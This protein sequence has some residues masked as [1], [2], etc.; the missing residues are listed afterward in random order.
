MALALILSGC[1]PEERIWWSPDG[2]QALVLV[3]G[4]LH[5]VKPG[6]ELGAP[7]MGGAKI[8]TTTSMAGLSWLRDGSG[9]VLCR[10]LKI[11]TWK[12]AARLVPA[13]EAKKIELLA[14]AV[15][16]WLAGAQ[17][18]ASKPSEAE[19]LLTSTVAGN[20]DDFLLALLCAYRSQKEAVAKSILKLPGGA[21]LLKKLNGENSQFTVNEICVV[22]FTGDGNSAAPHPLA[23]SLHAMAL[24]QV[25]PAQSVV[26]WLQMNGTNQIPSLEVSSLDGSEHA[27]VCESAKATFDWLPDGRSIIFATPVNGQSDSLAKI[28][29]VAV[30]AES[31]GLVKA[32]SEELGLALLLDPPRLQA[33]PDGR[34]LFSS[35][36]ATLPAAGP[37]FA[38]QLFILSADGKTVTGVATAPGALP[39][40]LS[41]FT[42]SPD[43]KLAAVVESGNDAVTV[44]DLATG[45]TEVVSPESPDWQ[46]RTMPAWK[47]PGELTFASLHNGTPQW[48]LWSKASGLSLLSEQWP[49]KS[50]DDW[51]KKKQEQKKEAPVKH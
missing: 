18:L 30:V 7:L 47:A 27:T 4:S 16:T 29:K 37:G 6:G 15:P 31:G 13:S 48:M 49:A 8:K 51:L 23:R 14:L 40:E 2:Q 3:E 12:E 20:E 26:A 5:L 46:C 28:Q 41:Y 25:S 24:P 22:H 39:A 9:F 45:A 19:S 11:A 17:K 1:L 10:K 36:P 44:V 43:G 35:Q 33:L 32:A 50:T 42:A 34:I 38:P 21:D